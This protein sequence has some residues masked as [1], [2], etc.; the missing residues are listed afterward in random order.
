LNIRIAYKDGNK[1]AITALTQNFVLNI[2][3][4]VEEENECADAVVTLKDKA[5]NH[6]MTFKADYATTKE[7]E[8]SYTA[9][10]NSMN[11]AGVASAD[12]VAKECQ[13]SYKL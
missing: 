12:G 11:I 4:N 8:Y 3:G 9:I 13:V 10:D 5:R 7:Y 2:V 6:E 1:E